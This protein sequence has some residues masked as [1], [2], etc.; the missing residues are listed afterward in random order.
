M[1]RVWLKLDATYV[2]DDRIL[3][4]GALAELLFV[5][6]I[7]YCRRRLTDGFVSAAAVRTLVVGIPEES[8]ALVGALVGVELW[9]P[10]DGGWMVRS[11]DKWQQTKSDLAADAER[12]RNERDRERERKKERD[13]GG[14]SAVCPSDAVLA[15]VP[16]FVEDDDGL[17]PELLAEMRSKLKATA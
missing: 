12:K 14:T 7:A 16:D 5:R 4:A 11:Y 8:A 6:S 9:L 2:E 13:I 1:S 17:V 3:E 15:V 10:C